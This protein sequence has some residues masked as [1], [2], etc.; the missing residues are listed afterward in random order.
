MASGKVMMG[1]IAL[2]W[3]S[4]T[5]GYSLGASPSQV[6]GSI[7]FGGMSVSGKNDEDCVADQLS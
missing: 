7:G 3:P 4:R 5:T 1:S 2:A 6:N